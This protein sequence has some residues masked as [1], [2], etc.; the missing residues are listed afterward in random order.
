MV[1][2]KLIQFTPLYH[3]LNIYRLRFFG[4]LL[5]GAAIWSVVESGQATGG[6]YKSVTHVGSLLLLRIVTGHIG[7]SGLLTGDGSKLSLMAYL[8]II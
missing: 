2:K 7:L 4:K 8:R 6:Y 5:K 1:V 3:F